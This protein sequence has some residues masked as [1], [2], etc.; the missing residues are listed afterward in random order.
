M[1]EICPALPCSLTKYF[2]LPLFLCVPPN[3]LYHD[4]CRQFEKPIYY[5]KLEEN[6]YMINLLVVG[7]ALL[8]DSN[9][10]SQ[11]DQAAMIRFT[12]MFRT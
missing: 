9:A 10:Y 3:V 7:I 5:G 4:C 11:T 1:T 8:L 12:E 6:D 2:T